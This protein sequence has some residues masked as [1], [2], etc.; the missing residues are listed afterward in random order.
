MKNPCFFIFIAAALLVPAPFIIALPTCSSS[1]GPP[2]NNDTRAATSFI[3]ERPRL[4]L[5][6]IRLPGE[7]F[8]IWIRG[9][10][11]DGS[12]NFNISLVGN[13]VTYHLSILNL[14]MDADR[15]KL[16]VTLANATVIDLYDLRMRV[17]DLEEY[18]VNAVSVIPEYKER[19]KFIQLTDI[20][21]DDKNSVYNFMQAAREINLI[22]PELVVITGDSID[23]DP[24]GSKTPDQ[25]Q[26]DMFLDICKTLKVPVYVIPGNH[27]YSYRDSNGIN[28]YSTSINP[29]LDYSFNYGPHH[30]IGM[31]CGQWQVLYGSV[32]H[33][34]NNV[35]SFT[36]EQV[37]WLTRDLT[38]HNGDE[39]RLI[40]LH[41]PLKTS[42]GKQTPMWHKDDVENL[43]VEHDVKAFIAGHTHDDEILDGNG[44][45]LAGDWQQPTYPLYIQTDTAGA[46]DSVEGC[47]YRV[48][49]IDNDTFE[50]YTYDDDGDGTRS[51]VS[52]TPLG[53]LKAEFAWPGGEDKS[54]VDV[55]VTNDQN[56]DLMDG[57]VT[58]NMDRPPRGIDYFAEGGRVVN[59]LDTPDRQIIHVQ[60][61]V[62]RLTRST[63]SVMQRDLTPPRIME[64]YSKSGDDVSGVYEKGGKIE[65]TVQEEGRET[66]LIGAMTIRDP[67]GHPG[68]A[69]AAMAD[70][71]GGRYT[72]QWDTK[73]VIPGEN[74]SISARLTDDAGNSDDGSILSVPALHIT[75]RDTT[76]PMVMRVSSS[77]A[78]STSGMYSLGS[79]VRIMVEEA[80]REEGLAGS[81]RIN[82]SSNW[83]HY[84]ETFSLSESGQ[85]AYILDWNT[86]GLPEGNY[87]IES[88]LVDGSGNVG[89]GLSYRPE[90]IIQL[91]DVTP[92]E[93]RYIECFVTGKGGEPDRDG[94]YALG[95]I[96]QF[97]V[98]E[99]SLEGNLTGDIHLRHAESGATVARVPLAHMADSPGKYNGSWY[100][101]GND[102]GIYHAD[103]T[104]SD[105]SGNSD[106]DGV[107]GNPDLSF[108][109]VDTVEPQ[110][111]SS[112]PMDGDSDVPVD[113]DILIRFSEPLIQN[114]LLVGVTLRDSYGNEIPLSFQWS[115]DNCSALFS[116]DHILSYKRSYVLSLSSMVR[117]RA[118]NPL[119]EFTITFTTR[120]YTPMESV[121]TSHTVFPQQA[122]VELEVG[123]GQSFGIVLIDEET[124]LLPLH[125][126]WYLNDRELISGGSE[127]VYNLTSDNLSV[128]NSYELKITVTGE[129]VS[130]SYSW[131]VLVIGSDGDDEGGGGLEGVSG[132]PVLRWAY[133]IG[134]AVVVLG[135]AIISGYLLIRRRIRN[136]EARRE[137]DLVFVGNGPD[138]EEKT[139]RGDIEEATVM[140]PASVEIIP[141][142][143]KND[144]REA[145]A[146]PHDPIERWRSEIIDLEPLPTG[147]NG[148]GKANESTDNEKTI[149]NLRELVD[150]FIHETGEL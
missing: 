17:D 3:L 70:Q 124:K 115:G 117:D 89:E 111:M 2:I 78:G 130:I 50:Y 119:T 15:W 129:D 94:E 44:N 12:S 107:Q 105:R 120:G 30:F 59:V 110:V 29:L 106:E 144:A 55:T 66:G 136:S 100:S 114:T 112:V 143:S 74:Y 133:M 109:L 142:P 76:A 85:G 132:D 41:A 32:P 35:Q 91:V 84:N 88:R 148:S 147:D 95:D 92:P 83:G 90:L 37:E 26:A 128:D 19:F 72:Y 13:E 65:I 101:F 68:I 118:G 79:L 20:H 127:T 87:W 81:L 18:Q 62:P 138:D 61:S 96:L 71:G 102:I 58:L 64:M 113:T 97:I 126:C 25:E 149:D 7:T 46:E 122:R 93:V 108:T 80:D 60:F 42:G 52:S 131:I 33:P 123:G 82:H 36:E 140:D 4:T 8:E 54:S 67:L 116:S 121:D 150:D 73:N 146:T 43:M 21:I 86:E 51:A 103:V 98:E 134:G 77:S 10:G 137:L 56:E 5:P 75:I 31:N 1:V 11:M 23:C 24:T 28:I 139:D 48:F 38:L 14:V 57:R 9:E 47:S 34:D 135:L 69:D 125:Y 6:A 16:E 53:L 63:F 27:E 39:M 99:A 141:P 45:V 22:D 40:F 104:L 49:M 145:G